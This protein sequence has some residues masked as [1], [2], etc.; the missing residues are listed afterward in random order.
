MIPEL[1]VED[2]TEVTNANSY[3]DL[4]YIKHFCIS[5]GLELPASD[6]LI[7]TAAVLAMN[8]L[9]SKN[10]KYMGHATSA[11]QSLS[12][13][14]KLLKVN[15]YLRA[16]DEIPKEIKDAQSYATYLITTGEDLQPLVGSEIVNE[17]SVGSLSAKFKQNEIVGD[18]G[19]NYFA[20]V[21]DILDRLYV[22]D[23]GYRITKRHGF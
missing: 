6:T 23:T 13:P 8:Y 1:I 15:N 9:E 16:S 22:K 11:T 3:C 10:D 2:G 19:K 14:R 4:D 7:I 12:F 5:R 21:D 17:A 18:D 20:P